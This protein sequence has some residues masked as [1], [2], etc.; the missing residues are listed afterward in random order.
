VEAK[1]TGI[2]LRV[3]PFGGV[4]QIPRSTALELLPVMAVIDCGSQ[5]LLIEALRE[6]LGPHVAILAT[7]ETVPP[8]E[9]LARGASVFLQKPLQEHDFEAASLEILKSALSD[10]GHPV[11]ASA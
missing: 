8:S 11:S 3:H 1:L 10:V 6:K 5:S 9:A 2:H 7:S 4:N